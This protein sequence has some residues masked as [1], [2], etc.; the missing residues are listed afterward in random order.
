MAAVTAWAPSPV[1]LR[2]RLSA[3]LALA[4][5]CGPV[6]LGA[7]VLLERRLGDADHAGDLVL[8]DAVGGERPDLAACGLARLVGRAP[9]LAVSPSAQAPC[10]RS[11]AARSAAISVA[12]SGSPLPVQRIRTA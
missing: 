8:G 4:S 11:A 2:N 12:A 3:T 6:E 5:V 7:V 9:A 10:C 1:A